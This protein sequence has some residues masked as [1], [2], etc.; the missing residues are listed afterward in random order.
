[1]IAVEKADREKVPLTARHR[2]APPTRGVRS[3]ALLIVW[4][5]ALG[6][7]LIAG[8]VG[9]YWLYG[10]SPLAETN[11]A[12][13]EEAGNHKPAATKSE[14]RSA[15]ARGAAAVAQASAPAPAPASGAKEAVA[16]AEAL[17]P[18]PPSASVTV[19]VKRLLGGFK[20]ETITYAVGHVKNNTNGTLKVVKVI[21]RIGD[22]DDKE[23]GQ[24]TQVLL[25]LPAGA[26]AP[27]VA[28]WQH[29]EGV[30][31]RRW[32][33]SYQLDPIGVPQ[34]LPP[35]A[36]QDAIAIRDPN[37]SATTGKIKVLVVNR[38]A[39]P[40]P[41]VQFYAILTAPDGKIV[42]AAKATVDQTLAP[43]KPQ[44]VTFPWANCPGSLVQGVE[45]SVQA[46]L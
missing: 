9:I 18:E 38:G 44:E 4:L 45:V 25:N 27:L 34:D 30:I 37:A 14:K 35:V 3:R 19:K 23:L 17:A 42:G 39:L 15:S 24:A 22:K 43:N 12:S 33:P 36:A 21:V 1:M 29:A 7:G 11:S 2:V 16:S 28:E 8:G 41:Q 46:G 10:S 40:L 6:L 32:M 13:A 26:T 31:G 20:D 5:V